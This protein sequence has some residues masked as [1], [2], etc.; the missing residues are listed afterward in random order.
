MNKKNLNGFNISTG[1]YCDFISEILYYAKQRRSAYACVANVHMFIEAYKNETFNS[2]I[3]E[4]DIITPDGVPLCWWL[5]L[6]YGVK[7]QRVAGMD[8][9]P[10]L[11]KEMEK[12]EL[13][14]YF[15]GGSNELIKQTAI[16]LKQQYPLLPVV[17]LKSPP[18]R[19]LT[20]EE[21]ELSINDIN[22]SEAQLVFVILG[23]PRQEKWMASMKGRINAMM[24]GVGGALPVLIGMQKRAPKWMQRSGLEWFYRLAQEPVRLFKRYAITNTIFL[25]LLSKDFIRSFFLKKAY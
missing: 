14:V 21:E 5:R 22:S 17:G 20:K 11:L 2:I 16:H 12:Q 4:A 13:K 3:N 6:K 24:V 8:L 15:Y 18:F 25:Y 9:L 7:Q 10:D 23:C 19:E 1:V